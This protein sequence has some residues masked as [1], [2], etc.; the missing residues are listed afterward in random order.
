MGS[1]QWAV[2]GG[3]RPAFLMEVEGGRQARQGRA[4][5]FRRFE[6]RIPLDIG[7]G[8][9][10]GQGRRGTGPAFLALVGIGCGWFGCE[11]VE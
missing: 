4:G 11:W 5:H 10:S 2:K 1:G 8:C 3:P 9:S 6:N 7:P